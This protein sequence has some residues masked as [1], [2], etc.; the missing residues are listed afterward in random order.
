MPKVTGLK[1]T[2]LQDAEV[3]GGASYSTLLG[4]RCLS[5][6]TSLNLNN[7]NVLLTVRV[8]GGDITCSR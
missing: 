6:K 7:S 8:Q 5:C 2:V 1:V 4:A 3:S